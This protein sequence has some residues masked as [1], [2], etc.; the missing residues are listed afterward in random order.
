VKKR[1]L[2]VTWLPPQGPVKHRFDGDIHKATWENGVVK[3][4]GDDGSILMLAADSVKTIQL[5]EEEVES[6][7]I[8][9]GLRDI[10]KVGPS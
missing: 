6:P 1:F 4:K 8:P 9:P 7:I 5:V 2:D 3:I 10:S